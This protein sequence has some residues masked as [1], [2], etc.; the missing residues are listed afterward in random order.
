MIVETERCCDSAKVFT[1]VVEDKSVVL[2]KDVKFDEKF[3]NRSTG[4]YVLDLRDWVDFAFN[5]FVK[6][7]KV[8]YPTD[9]VIFLGDDEGTTYPRRA[10]SGGKNTDLDESIE[11]SFKLW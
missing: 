4:K 3:V 7:T 11:F 2:H 10:T 5:S 6:S 1:F 8:G 9:C